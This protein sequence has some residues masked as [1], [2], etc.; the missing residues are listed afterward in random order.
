M[1][2][3][4]GP[5]L[6][7]VAAIG[8]GSDIVDVANAHTYRLMAHD[9]ITCTID[10]EGALRCWGRDNEGALGNGGAQNIGDDESRCSVDPIDLG[11]PVVRLERVDDGVC[12]VLEHGRARCW[13]PGWTEPEQYPASGVEVVAQAP[14]L[15]IVGTRN[16]KCALLEGGAVRCWGKGAQ[17]GYGDGLDRTLD[18]D[19]Q[20]VL[21]VLDDVPVGGSVVKLTST[22]SPIERSSTC[23][24]LTTGAV[25]CWGTSPAL[26]YGTGHAV[27]DDETP[28]EVGDVPLGGTAVDLVSTHD[29]QCVLL[30]DQS[31]RCWGESAA[32]GHYGYGDIFAD[33]DRIGDDETPEAM[34]PVP[35]DEPVV[36]VHGGHERTCVVLEGGRAKCWGRGFP[37]LV[38]YGPWVSRLYEPSEDAIQLGGEVQSL[39]LGTHHTCAL[40]D[41]G[42]RCWGANDGGQ[43]GLGNTSDIGFQGHPEDVPL[44]DDCD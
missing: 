6:F 8:C 4:A 21:D 9:A 43:L 1:R 15:Q 35:V 25:R 28:A 2:R 29:G 16:V 12:A 39:A 41:V 18:S 44:V 17:I 23:A 30:E 33:I 7:G 14:I 10:Q 27:G 40:L 32:V 11:A 24:L 20:I 31:I 38:G 26:G 37:G 5:I 36:T 22:A 34:G 13:G 19:P 3:A 42:I